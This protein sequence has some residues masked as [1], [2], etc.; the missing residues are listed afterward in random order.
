MFKFFRNITIYLRVVGK[1]L[2]Q[3][4]IVLLFS[5]PGDKVLINVV[6][7]GQIGPV[8]FNFFKTLSPGLKNK[9]ILKCWSAIFPTTL[10]YMV[11]LESCRNNIL[12]YVC[13]PIQGDK[14][15]IQVEIYRNQD[16]RVQHILCISPNFILPVLST[17]DDWA[18]FT[19]A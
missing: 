4:F 6:R 17:P 1:M 2:D 18:S 16:L 5:N 8:V 15:L 7:R 10:I 3:H 14:I 9:S 12:M 11:M 13:S 19:V